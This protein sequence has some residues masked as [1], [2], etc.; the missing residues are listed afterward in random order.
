MSQLAG[1]GLCGLLLAIVGYLFIKK[2]RELRE[3]LERHADETAELVKQHALELK[4]ARD[5]HI[6]DLRQESDKRIEDSNRLNKMAHDIQRE[7]SS[8]IKTLGE[9]LEW[10][11][12][13]IRRRG[14]NRQDKEDDDERSSRP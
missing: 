14:H 12:Q 10:L 9:M 6:Q 7:A 8:T 13:E 4:E 5:R 1:T 3:A 11:R 2:D